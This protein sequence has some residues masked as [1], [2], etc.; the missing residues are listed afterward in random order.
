MLSD[1]GGINFPEFELLNEC[2]QTIDQ[3]ETQPGYGSDD[4]Q[5]PEYRNQR[6]RQSSP[7]AEHG[8]QLIECGVKGDGQHDA[9]DDKRQ[10]GTNENE[11]PVGKEADKTEV[12]RHFDESRVELTI[13]EPFGVLLGHGSLSNRLAHVRLAPQIPVRYFTHR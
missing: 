8:R 5:E 1:G 3:T 7:C 9:P 13:I 10:K 6:R 11:G 4:D 2:F 12:N